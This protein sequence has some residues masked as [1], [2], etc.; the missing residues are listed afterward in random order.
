MQRSIRS[1]APAEPRLDHSWYTQDAATARAVRLQGTGGGGGGGRGGDHDSDSAAHLLQQPKFA[2]VSVLGGM[3]AGGSGGKGSGVAK[4]GSGKSGTSS[5]GA[6]PPVTAAGRP[7]TSSSSSSSSSPS[8]AKAAPSLV[9]QERQPNIELHA[10]RVAA[11]VGRAKAAAE[12][13][14]MKKRAGG[15]TAAK[16]QPAPGKQGAGV[17]VSK[18]LGCAAAV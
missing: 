15:G 17:E 1:L 14:E 10:E 8:P 12:A 11:V 16:Q 5:S 2:T 7:A 18:Q 9:Q 13:L 3:P 6:A 4:A